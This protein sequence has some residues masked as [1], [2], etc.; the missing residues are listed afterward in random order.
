M[1]DHHLERDL[2]PAAVGPRRLLG[3]FVSQAGHTQLAVGADPT[4]DGP[5]GDGEFRGL[6]GVLGF[7][8]KLRIELWPRFTWLANS[9]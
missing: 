2:N 4:L 3:V 9:Q 1:L 8:W 5:I 7:H 6:R